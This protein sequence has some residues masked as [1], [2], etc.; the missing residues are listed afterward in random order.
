MRETTEEADTRLTPPPVCMLQRG[1]MCVVHVPA[2][3][4]LHSSRSSCSA[5]R[6]GPVM[7]ER[8][9]A[10]KRMRRGQGDG[11]HATAALFIVASRDGRGAEHGASA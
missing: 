5:S 9:S 2:C 10:W 7:G 6:M 8:S 11:V 4:P 1:W 3:S